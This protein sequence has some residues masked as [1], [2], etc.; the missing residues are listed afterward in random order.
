MFQIDIFSLYIT[1][2][3]WILAMN[4][5]DFPTSHRECFKIELEAFIY[6]S[7]QYNAK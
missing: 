4:D 3:L 1:A 5:R 6:V 7:K 2:I